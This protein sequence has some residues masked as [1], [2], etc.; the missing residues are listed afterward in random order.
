M[1][2]YPIPLHPA[3]FLFSFPFTSIPSFLLWEKDWLINFV[4]VH[5]SSVFF[6]SGLQ[7]F[8]ASV[9]DA[10][11]FT[12]KKK[13]KRSKN[14]FIIHL[15][16]QPVLCLFF[17]GEGWSCNSQTCLKISIGLSQDRCHIYFTLSTSTVWSMG[18]TGINICVDCLEKA[19]WKMV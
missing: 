6:G 18:L 15:T 5:K 11:W 19:V 7:L 14:T 1:C 4:F 16:C 3:I 8:Y 9:Y 10:R 12:F 17:F 13:E 2:Q